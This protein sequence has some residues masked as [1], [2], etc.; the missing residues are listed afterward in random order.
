MT[1]ILAM[2]HYMT[3]TG[4][5]LDRLRDFFHRPAQKPIPPMKNAPE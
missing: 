4:R 5:W 3:T 2:T 1:T